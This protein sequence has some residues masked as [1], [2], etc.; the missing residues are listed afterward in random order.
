MRHVKN[1]NRHDE[2]KMSDTPCKRHPEFYNFLSSF[3]RKFLS[4]VSR[5]GKTARGFQFRDT[6]FERG[7]YRALEKIRRNLRT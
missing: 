4:T 5:I 2:E 6:M 3:F 7:D 1:S